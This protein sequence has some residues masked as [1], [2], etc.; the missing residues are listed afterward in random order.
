MFK[1][2]SYPF[3]GPHVDL[4]FFCEFVV[5][6]KIIVIVWLESYEFDM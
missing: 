4:I 3:Y 1:C 5:V 2:F 6:G